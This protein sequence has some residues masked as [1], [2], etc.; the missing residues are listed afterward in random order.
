MPRNRAVAIV[1]H[2]G[3]LL[4]IFRKNIKGEYYVFPGGGIDP[5][6]SSIDATVREAYEET[7][8]TVT[9]GKLVY[10]THH[11][12]GD[13]HYFYLCEYVSGE[14]VLQPETNEYRD[15][16]QGIDYYEPRWIPLSNLADTILYPIEIRDQLIKDVANGFGEETLHFDLKAMLKWKKRA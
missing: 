3:N 1:I 8:I 13:M 5:G 16:Q 14:P 7:S 12:N 11:D 15:I 6:E 2:E 10:E 4:T 9:P